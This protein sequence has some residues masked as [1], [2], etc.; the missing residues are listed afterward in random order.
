MNVPDD[1]FYTEW[2]EWVRREGE[3]RASASPI[4]RKLS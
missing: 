3:T 2:H 1:L 4:T